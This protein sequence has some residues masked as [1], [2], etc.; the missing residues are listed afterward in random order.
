MTQFNVTFERITPESA[1]HGDFDEIGFISEGVSLRQA[2]CDV[3]GFYDPRMLPACESDCY[4]VHD[5][6][7]FIFYDVED[8][9]EYSESRCIHLWDK[10]TPSSAMRIARLFNCYGVPKKGSTK[11]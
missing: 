1:E 6:R 10:V 7:S 9:G 2:I 8:T 11:K 4:P 5:P 3:C